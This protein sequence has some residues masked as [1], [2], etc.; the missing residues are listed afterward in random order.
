MGEEDGGSDTP[1]V[2]N[3]AT[4]PKSIYAAWTL[5]KAENGLS[6]GGPQL[7]CKWGLKRVIF[8]AGLQ[9]SNALL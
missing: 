5:K 3:S 1:K 9:K 7:F 6:A 2:N 8:F 4:R